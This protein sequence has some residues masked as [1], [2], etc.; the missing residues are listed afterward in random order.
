MRVARE[1][2][3]YDRV[4]KQLTVTLN[5]RKHKLGQY[6]DA[7]SA[8]RAAKAF[9]EQQKAQQAAGRDQ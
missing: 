5:G 9:I 8:A 7:E 2:Y 6:G 4:S 3:Q 1:G